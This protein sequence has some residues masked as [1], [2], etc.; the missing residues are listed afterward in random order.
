MPLSSQQTVK[1]ANYLLSRRSVQTP[2]G[3]VSLL[4]ALDVLATN[5]YEKPICIALMESENIV[6]TKQPLIR[7]KICNILGKPL[8]STPTV[9]AN[10]ATRIGDEVVVLKKKNFQVDPKDK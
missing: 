10:T 2:K 7:V 4:S 1:F 9:V 6:S 3:V 5:E 8:A